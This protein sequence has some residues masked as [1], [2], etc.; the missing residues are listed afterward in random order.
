MGKCNQKYDFYDIF[1]IRNIFSTIK[2]RDDSRF[3]HTNLIQ[4]SLSWTMRILYFIKCLGK[5]VDN[6]VDMLDAY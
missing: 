1:Q 2:N 4:K 6:V 5:V 3:F